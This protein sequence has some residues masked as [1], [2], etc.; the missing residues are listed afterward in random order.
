MG[1]ICATSPKHR[2]VPDFFI[3]TFNTVFLKNKKTIASAENQL[4]NDI[5]IKCNSLEANTKKSKRGNAHAVSMF[6]VDFWFEF[7]CKPDLIS[8]VDFLPLVTILMFFGRFLFVFCFKYFFLLPYFFNLSV[9]LL[10]LLRKNNSE[11]RN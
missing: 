4:H 10:L 5:P 9:F 1:V 7:L 11:L 8:L 2:V 3:K 6:Y